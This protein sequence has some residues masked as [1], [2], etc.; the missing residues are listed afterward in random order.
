MH[1]GKLNQISLVL[2]VLCFCS[3]TQTKAFSKEQFNI[4]GS[5][6]EQSVGSKSDAEMLRRPLVGIMGFW[7][8]DW[9]LRVVVQKEV[10]PLSEVQSFAPS[11]NFEYVSVPGV[12]SLPELL[13]GRLPVLHASRFFA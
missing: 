5:G 7:F 10:R 8:P 3:N 2:P 1:H 9:R 6:V 4:V 13:I 11:D 12:Q